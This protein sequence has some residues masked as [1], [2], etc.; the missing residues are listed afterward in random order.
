MIKWGFRVQYRMRIIKLAV[1][2]F[3]RAKKIFQHPYVST[4]IL[5]FG[6]FPWTIEYGDGHKFQSYD[7]FA[8]YDIKSLKN[9]QF[10][11]NF[12][13]RKVLIKNA[14]RG[15]VE[16]VFNSR[17]YDWLPVKDRIVIDVGANIGDSAIFFGLNGAEHV[18]AFEIVPSTF[19]L[20]KENINLNNLDDKI[21]V[22]NLGLGKEGT[23]RIPNDLVADGCFSTSNL[24][25]NESGTEVKIRSLN[26]VVNELSIENAVMK[27]DCEGCEY[28]VIN[29][30][31][32]ESVKKFSHIVGEYHYGYRKL[33]ETLEEAGFE[34]SATKPEPFY[35]HYNKNH[36][37]Y[38]GIFKA[39]RKV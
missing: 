14:E 23:I 34:F 36:Y 16:E 13:G 18:Y 4:L 21:T 28:D 26:E 29:P 38:T 17:T 24:Q 19:Q 22:F 11:T 1:S 27:I 5:M 33:K 37:A 20:C 6:K 3:P 10:E 7:P 32:L 2:N 8:F 31:N 12:N 15:E 25:G 30:Q 9:Y 39:V 35:S